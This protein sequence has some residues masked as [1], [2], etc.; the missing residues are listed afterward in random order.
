MKKSIQTNK[1]PS[2]VGPYSQAMEMNGILFISG[3]VPLVPETGKII[4]GSIK[5]QTRRVLQNIEAIL[6]EAGYK[7]SDIVKT[8]VYLKDIQDFGA[9]NEVYSTVFSEDKP[10][11]AAFAVKDLPMNAMVE[12]DAIAIR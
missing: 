12:I 11:R 10:A 2:A 1:A 4:E 7:L 9:M 8:T 6:D 5:E 3:Q